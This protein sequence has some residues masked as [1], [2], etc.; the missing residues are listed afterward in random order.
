MFFLSKPQLKE[1]LGTLQPGDE[2]V[3]DGSKARFIDHDIYNMLH[4]YQETA[5]VQ[6]IRYELKNVLLKSRKPKR[7]PEALPN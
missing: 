4:D 2:V 7:K 1:A 5:Q 3:V 6:G